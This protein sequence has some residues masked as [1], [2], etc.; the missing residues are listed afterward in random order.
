[1]LKITYLESGLYLEYLQETVEDWLAL[2]VILALR[3]G[4]RLVVER[5]TASLLLPT[6]LVKRSALE[7]IARREQA[8]LLSQVDDQY[9][10]VSLSGTWLYSGEEEGVF[11]TM[12]HPS[13]EHLVFRLWQLAQSETSA[14]NRSINR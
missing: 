4:Q 6:A 8:A 14:I 2:R 12:L 1:M 5:T 11:V 13:I 9:M 7:P 10:E 3:M